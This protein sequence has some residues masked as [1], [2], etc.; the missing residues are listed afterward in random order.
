[1]TASQLQVMATANESDLASCCFNNVVRISISG[2]LIVTAVTQA[3]NL[4]VIRHAALRSEFHLATR[5]MCV[6][7]EKPIEVRYSEVTLSNERLLDREL[8]K[9]ARQET[10]AVFDLANGPLI[11]FHVAKSGQRRN[12]I[13]MS[14]H[15]L[16]IDHW[17]VDLLVDEF[18]ELYSSIVGQRPS[19]LPP[20]FS[21][22]D[23]AKW[24]ASPQITEQRLDN[25]AYWLDKWKHIGP[26][27][28]L[29]AANSEQKSSIRGYKATRE[30][31]ELNIELARKIATVAA[32]EK[33]TFFTFTLAGF[34]A[35]LCQIDG[36]ESIRVGIPAA[37]QTDFGENR[38]AGSCINTLPIVLVVKKEMTLRECL[39]IVRQ[40]V[41]AAQDHTPFTYLEIAS[42]SE[43]PAIEGR[44]PMITAVFNVDQ[45]N[46]TINFGEATAQYTIEARCAEQFEVA[47][48]VRNHGEHSSIQCYFC[49]DLYS[50]KERDGF[51]NAYLE[52]L[53][54]LAENPGAVIGDLAVNTEC[55]QA[56]S[57]ASYLDEPRS[58]RSF[59][60]NTC[61]AQG[62][63][64]IDAGVKAK[65]QL[66][67]VTSE[68]GL[69]V[70]Q[71][72]S[73][74]PIAQRA[75]QPLDIE[76]EQLTTA[77][78]R[79]QRSIFYGEH[80]ELYGIYRPVVKN[81]AADVAVL[82]CGPHGTEA[83][84]CQRIIRS[85]C[86]GIQAAGVACLRF[87]Y[88]GDADSAGDSEEADLAIWLQ[89]VRQSKQELQ[90][91]SGC[92][93]ILAVGMRIGATLLLRLADDEE[94][95]DLTLVDPIVDGQMELDAWRRKHK[96]MLRDN[97]TY[98]FG[99][100]AG[101]RQ[102]AY[103]EIAGFCYGNKMLRQISAIETNSV[104]P[105][106]PTRVTAVALGISANTALAGV[107][108]ETVG[109]EAR[110]NDP[111][112]VR[113]P[114]VNRE[115]IDVVLAKLTN[116]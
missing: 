66:A 28:Q 29:S 35:L 84:R 95:A 1:M 77:R 98:R 24:L 73:T 51:M 42:E 32:S 102:V 106:L 54:A 20:A 88:F 113:N 4:L 74:P 92:Q 49:N 64:L 55:S 65:R 38:V 100:F 115:L 85:M 56:S 111:L 93:K 13:F 16:A 27:K 2:E 25:K 46:H 53:R 36:D 61:S 40:E 99:R 104:K 71:W 34:V 30:T 8:E 44:L 19:V 105:S 75:S 39:V 90:R 78:N 83:S 17:S 79:M 3:A 43:R 72:S 103:E 96:D 109:G 116:V 45:E 26:S 12:E 107:R 33:S 52:V 9:I 59:F 41:Y 68:F 15:Q 50:A 112:Y 14:T 10:R 80:N 94:F 37:G 60:P 21:F 114:L 22:V 23:Y 108:F 18:A 82:I 57:S 101:R 63:S 89:N 69:H 86:D 47:M 48:S 97:Y 5:T 76:H 110:W 87:D 58:Y 67:S 91:L 81:S 7:V 6:A 11:R 31:R 70:P 62:D